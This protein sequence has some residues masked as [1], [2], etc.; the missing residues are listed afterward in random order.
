MIQFG[1]GDSEEFKKWD[2]DIKVED[3][4]LVAAKVT[5]SVYDENVL[6]K[7]AAFHSSP[8]GKKYTPL[9]SEM[10]RI[11]QEVARQYFRE[12]LSQ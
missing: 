6:N 7:A 8:V 3:I 11:S 4:N 2:A 10:T 1:H 12:L 5:V 9:K